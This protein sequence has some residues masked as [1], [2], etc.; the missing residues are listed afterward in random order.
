MAFFTIGSFMALWTI[1]YGV[2]QACTPIVVKVAGTSA[3]GF[4]S[5]ARNWVAALIAIPLAL[6]FSVMLIDGPTL[7][8]ILIGGL[9]VFGMIFA[10]NSSLHSYLI[11][12]LTTGER[13]TMDVG[14]YYMANA[15][16]RLVGTLLSGVAYQLGG[17]SACLVTAAVLLALSWL[18]ARRL[19]REFV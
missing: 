5:K 10:V 17:L 3:E 11:L 15:T 2:V 16:G 12:A 1:L 9:L 18:G 6:A 7:T 8:F 4:A 19:E 13:V 14:F